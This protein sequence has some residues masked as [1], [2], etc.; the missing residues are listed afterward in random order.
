MLRVKIKSVNSRQVE[1]SA[2]SPKEFLLYAWC[3]CCLCDDEG[4]L[5][6]KLLDLALRPSLLLLFVDF[7]LLLAV[8]PVSCS[9]AD[10]LRF[11]VLTL[12]FR[13]LATS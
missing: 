7:F 9:P 5:I 8:R 13:F 2:K 6:F 3:C 10:A 11:R 1:D 4:T 12:L